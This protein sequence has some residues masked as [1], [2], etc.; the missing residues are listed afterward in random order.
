MKQPISSEGLKATPLAPKPNFWLTVAK[1]TALA[2]VAALCLTYVGFMIAAAS[3]A[4]LSVGWMVALAG[5]FA[6]AVLLIDKSITTVR[7]Y[8]QSMPSEMDVSGDNEVNPSPELSASPDHSATQVT[9]ASGPQTASESVVV[10]P[11]LREDGAVAAAGTRATTITP[12]FF[13]PAP[14]PLQA[15]TDAADHSPKL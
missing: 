8:K 5:L 14:A 1:F 12:A 2:T 3:I 10:L 6:I 13:S 9:P 4:T 15:D 7:D 11:P